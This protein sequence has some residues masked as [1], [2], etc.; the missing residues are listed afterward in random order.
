M[1]F[2]ES[3]LLDTSSLLLAEFTAA[4]R[5]SFRLALQRL[6]PWEALLTQ[7]ALG[8]PDV[9]AHETYPAVQGA[10]RVIVKITTAP[11]S[12]VA[13]WAPGAAPEQSDERT[14]GW[15]DVPRSVIEMVDEETAAIAVRE[16][17]EMRGIHELL[18]RWEQS[19]ELD[20]RLAVIQDIVERVESIYIF[21]GRDVFSKSDA[22]SN[23]LTRDDL[24]GKLRR[25]PRE[26]W[27]ES[28]CLF[29]VAAHCL[30]LSG[31]SVRFEEFNGKQLSA[32][33]LREFLTNRYAAYCHALGRDPVDLHGLPLL[34]LAG[35]IREL[36]PEAD[37]TDHMRYRRISGMT[38]AKSEYLAD[39]PLPRDP[40]EMPAL[41]AAFGRERLDL[42]ATGDV[43]ADLRAMT[44]AAAERDA[45]NPPGDDIGVR[46]ELLA[47]I[48]S[49]AVRV[50]DSDYGMSSSVRDL[51]SLRGAEAGGPEGV[52]ALR[53]ADF[54]CCCLPHP[55]RMAH[56]GDEDVPILWRSAQ[57]MQYNRWHFIPGEFDRADIPENRHYFFPPQIPDIAEHADHIHGGHVASAVR[58]TIRAPGAQVWR[59]PFT[60]FGH[61]FRGCYDIRLVRMQGPPYT[62]GELTDAVRH[63][64]LVDA[65]W[66]ALAECLD[67]GDIP[68]GPIRGFDKAWYED[69][70]WLAAFPYREPAEAA[71]R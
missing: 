17:A 65:F 20:K 19:G 43:R 4:G 16:R 63:T 45:E 67:T 38:L 18:A 33:G 49:S 50:T 71:A 9:T 14:I 11:L 37:R 69:R 53:K 56:V 34:E 42:T 24:V 13:F 15:L 3:E 48:V 10:S 8:H 58:Y 40:A 46:G 29:V 26:Q 60:V 59:E 23:T 36:M 25:T 47:T 41:I 22:G 2:V 12:G 62:L 64:S 66:R 44:R 51:A 28:D 68:V 54:F 39:F 57:R 1:Q 55:T 6:T 35:R 52:L 32:V 27:R 61:G 70:G 21:I 30:F 5:I 7:H 31:R